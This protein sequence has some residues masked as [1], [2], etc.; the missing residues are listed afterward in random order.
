MGIANTTVAAALLAGLF[1]G[2]GEDWVGR[3]TGVD[4]AGLQRK[5]DAVRRGLQRHQPDPYD[6]VGVFAALGGFEI[7]GLAGVVLGAA[8]ARVPVVVDGF[9]CSSA[10]LVAARIAPHVTY[11]L[12]GGH[13]SV[14][15]GHR[16]VLSE[17]ELQ[18]LLDLELR[19]GEGTGAALAMGLVDAALRI[20]HEMATFDAAGVSDSGA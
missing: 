12:I 8:A 18:P 2:V 16:R 19:L 4:D 20:L 15:P 5:R 13:R 10:A 7:A 14:E 9:I 1:G 6:P 11:Y 17:L 3:G